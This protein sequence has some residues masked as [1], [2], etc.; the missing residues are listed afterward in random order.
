MVRRGSLS[1]T[2]PAGISST[3]AVADQAVSATE[4]WIGVRPASTNI[5]A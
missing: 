4:I 1:A 3:K 2:T 5:T